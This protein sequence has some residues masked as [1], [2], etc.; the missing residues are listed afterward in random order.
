MLLFTNGKA[1]GIPFMLSQAVRIH[2]LPKAASSGLQEACTGSILSARE[3]RGMFLCMSR[4]ICQ[5]LSPA[6]STPLLESGNQCDCSLFLMQIFLA[7]CSQTTSRRAT[8]RGCQACG[9]QPPTSTTTAPMEERLC[10]SLE[11]GSSTCAL[12]VNARTMRGLWISAF[13]GC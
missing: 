10:P 6:D 1:E 4:S 11:V 9:C 5:W 3:C 12:R 7:M 13:K 8:A 2:H